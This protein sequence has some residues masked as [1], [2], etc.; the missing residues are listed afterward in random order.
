[1]PDQARRRRPGN[2]RETEKKEEDA[3]LKGP[4][5]VIIIIAAAVVVLL[6]IGAIYLFAS[7]GSN[8]ESLAVGNIDKDV[9]RITFDV[10]ATPSGLGEYTGDVTVEITF[11]GVEEP[12]YSNKVRI[13]DGWGYEEVAYTDFIWGNGEYTVTAK[14]DGKESSNTFII[15][16]VA[17]DLM[18]DWYGLNSDVS[19]ST[20][21][22]Q[23]ELSI[24][25]MF[26]NTT[27]PLSS[28]PQGYDLTGNIETPDGS[29]IA[30][31]SSEFSPSLLK[32]Q[33][34]VDHTTVGEYKFTGT[35]VNTFCRSDSPYRTINV[36]AGETFYYDSDPFAMAGEDITASLANGE[37]E[38]TFDG[39][40]SWDDGTIVEY[41]WDFGDGQTETSSQP[42]IKHTY[43]EEGI[44][45]VSLLVEDDSGR[46]SEGQGGTSTSLK[47]T[48]NA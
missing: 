29:D 24:T 4:S 2:Q 19:M 31:S 5:P 26:G 3:P 6:I 23:V 17:T 8:V 48:V 14:G 46:T 45:Y 27:R 43:T 18:I 41:S 7:S 35:L 32:L 33:K 37:A 42:S 1:M 39:S 34:R 9:D 28:L 25:Y 20:P 12:L 30:I 11:E 21:E 36:G 13:N 38:V 16:N 15:R 40:N 44:Y 47:V 22:V 10:I